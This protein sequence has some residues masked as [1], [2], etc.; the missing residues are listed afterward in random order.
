MLAKLFSKNS[1]SMRRIGLATLIL[2][3][4]IFLYFLNQIEKTPLI[5]SSG[6]TF[7]KAVVVA[8]TKDNLAVDGRRYGH[9]VVRLRMIT[10][11]LKGRIVTA[12]SDSGYLFGVACAPRLKVVTITSVSGKTSVTSVYSKDRETAIYVFIGLFLLLLGWIGGKNGFKTALGLVFTFGCIVYLY[13]PLI[14]RGYSPFYAAVIVAIVTTVVTMGL[15]GGYTFKTV[16]AIL[17]TVGGVICAGVCAAGFGAVAGITGLNVADVE[18][19]LFVEQMTRIK[20]GGLLFSGIL[21]ASL[22]AVMDVGI[23]IASTINEIY[24]HNPALTKKELFSAGINVGRDLIGTMANT[25]IL[26]FTGGSLSVLVLDYA[27]DLPYR[28]IINS[29]STG[30]EI[31]QGISGSLGMILTVPLV[32]LIA[33]Q[34]IP[35]GK[36]GPG[37]AMTERVAE[38]DQT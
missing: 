18:A 12:T 13:L 32:A 34:L 35:L 17:G 29:Y 33:S 7:E 9:Q 30:I 38:A 2:G 19:L 36:P 31:M 37:C 27:Y 22:G 20:I 16:S 28:Q 3:L 23:S 8:I 11:K 10:G 1:V 15:I 4:L 25:L 14:Y 26:A 5:H 21:I 6:R 24:R